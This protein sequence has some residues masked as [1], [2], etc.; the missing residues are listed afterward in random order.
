MLSVGIPCG[1]LL[2]IGYPVELDEPLAPKMFVSLVIVVSI[3]YPFS[4]TVVLRVTVTSWAMLETAKRARMAMMY[5]L[6]I[7]GR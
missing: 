2:T 6:F 7:F 3:V 4:L 5:D 1:V